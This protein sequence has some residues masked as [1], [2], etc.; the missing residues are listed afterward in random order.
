MNCPCGQENP[1]SATHCS[2]CGKALRDEN[3]LGRML[4]D[5]AAG[6]GL[7]L[8]LAVIFAVGRSGSAEP[9]EPALTTVATVETGKTPEARPRREGP[10]L[11]AVTPKDYDD[12]GKLLD[13]LGPGYRWEAISFDDLLYPDVLAKYDVVFFTC[14]KVPPSWRSRPGALRNIGDLRR[15]RPQIRTD[16]RDSLRK[17]VAGGGTLYASDWRLSALAVAFPEHVDF[18]AASPGDKQT[19]QA[20]VLDAGLQRRIGRTI[21][22]EF[23]KPSWYPASVQGSDV[24]TC[25]RGRY[26]TTGGE[27]R[28]APLLVRFA[29]ENGTVVFTSFHN[30]AQNSQT[31]MELLRYLVFASV[32]AREEVSV[33]QSMVRGGFSPVEGN[34][35]TASPGEQSVSQVYH[36][37]KPGDLRFVLAF[38]GPGARLRLTV[39]G[40]DGRRLEETGRSTITLSAP[41]APAGDWKYTV[42]AVEIPYRNFPFSMT[43]GQRE[44][45]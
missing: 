17:Y 4:V 24:V 19:V 32:M 9:D 29:H 20:D 14:G 31:E 30:E 38:Q 23:D 15:I 3:R 12:M 44:K 25:M 6:L 39:T 33:R 5:V 26:K 45:E 41:D 34:L 18:D 16:L 28:T 22:L 8:A 21:A 2:R 35:L 37:D 7:V 43:V 1:D 10:M 27:L 36:A 13:T 42:T 11:L 40:P